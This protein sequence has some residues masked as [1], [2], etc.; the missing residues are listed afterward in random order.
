MG[1]FGG[2]ELGFAS[3]LDVMFVHDP[4]PGADETAAGQAG[5]GDRRGIA[6]LLM[7]PS[8]DPPVDLDADLRPEGRAAAGPLV[9]VVSRR[10]TSAGPPPGRRRHCC[11]RRLSPVHPNWAGALRRSHRSVA[12]SG[13]RPE[14]GLAGSA[15]VEGTHGIR[16][17]TAWRRSDAAYKTRSRWPVRCGMGR[18]VAADGA[19]GCP[20]LANHEHARGA[21]GCVE[22]MY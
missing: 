7:S 17:V 16:A 21:R 15:S 9:G 19:R 22:Q 18:P 6:S 8:S 11:A 4:L 10:T 13:R 2:R 12:L 1:R 14:D 5:H 3:D 20:P